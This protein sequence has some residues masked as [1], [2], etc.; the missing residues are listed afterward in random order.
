VT[1]VGRVAWKSFH[2]RRFGHRTPGGIDD[3]RYGED[4]R[5]EVLADENRVELLAV[6]P[7][8]L[9]DLADGQAS[10]VDDLAEAA[11]EVRGR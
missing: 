3:P 5:V 6:H 7:G 2:F 4:A 8:G 11:G 1:C 10:V 9:R